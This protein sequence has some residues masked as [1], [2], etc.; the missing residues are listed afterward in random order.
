MSNFVGISGTYQPESEDIAT[1]TVVT[2]LPL[3]NPLWVN[4]VRVVGPIL[5]PVNPLTGA[6]STPTTGPCPGLPKPAICDP[7]TVNFL[8]LYPDRTAISGVVPANAPGDVCTDVQLKE[9]YSWTVATSGTT[10]I[11]TAGAPVASTTTPGILLIDKAPASGLPVAITE[12]GYLVTLTGLT[13]ANLSATAGIEG[14]Q[15]S[16]T[17]GIA[18]GQIA[19]VAASAVTGSHTLPDGVLS[20]NV[21]LLNAG[22]NE[23]TGMV[24]VGKTPAELVDVSQ[25][26]GTGR[27]ALS[28]PSSTGCS[29]FRMVGDVADMR[30]GQAGSSVTAL[31]GILGAAYVCTISNTPLLLGAN[32]HTKIELTGNGITLMDAVSSTH[33][34]AMGGLSTALTVQTASYAAGATDSVI[35]ANAAGLTITLPSGS[36]AGAGRQYTV[37]N[38]ASGTN[39]TVTAPTGVT[40]DGAASNTAMTTA[41]AVTR[42]I[43]DGTNWL[44]I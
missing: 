36:A 32:Q 2:I 31:D 24:G 12:A 20:T 13:S 4:G 41:Y 33:N 35:V 28:N 42:W 6:W 27:V 39:T 10:P 18:S 8:I 22:S 40:L 11:T 17:A 44:S 23:F 25:T 19:S 16:A 14:S 21:P 26:G 43:S 34:I 1:G 3:F 9:N 5:C 15:L 29:E 30:F 37:K 38:G 7:A